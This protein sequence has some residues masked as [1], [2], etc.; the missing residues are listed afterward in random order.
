M[1]SL[2][3]ILLAAAAFA[4]IASAIPTTPVAQDGHALVSGLDL[5]INLL[6]KGQTP[7]GFKNN[8]RDDSNSPAD[9]FKKC[10]DGLAVVVVKIKAAIYCEGGAEKVDHN[11]VIGLLKDIL[12]LLVTLLAELKAIV[13]VEGCDFN[14]L[15]GLVAG[16]LIAV[17]EILFLVIEVVG[18]VD[19]V[20]CGVI[21]SIGG[22]LCEILTLVFGLVEGLLAAV[23]LLLVSPY[24]DHCKSIGFVNVLAI[25]GL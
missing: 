9:S 2:R 7:H 16:L 11:V 20:L 1:F 17:A 5:D 21:A 4:T 15:S 23:V 19:T 13:K 10:S 18:T 24:A 14:V 25:L 8:R 3:S 22:L 12:V 6:I